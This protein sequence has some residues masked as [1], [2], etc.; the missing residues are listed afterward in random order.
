MQFVC[1]NFKDLSLE[2]LYEIGRLRQ[3]V[4]VLEQNCPYVD[5]DGKD[6]YCFH[7]MV[8]DQNGQLQA[9]SR[10]VPQGISYSE[11]ISIGR[12]VNSK[13]VRGTGIGRLLMEKS[14]ESCFEIWGKRKIRISA[15]TYLLDFYQSLGFESTG[16]E[17]LEDDIPHTEMLLKIG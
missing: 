13:A 5:F 6:Q 9:Y 4:F 7:L 15:Q 12:V 14:I 17:Y 11:D 3:E 10:L 16:K 2:E 1:K 8:L